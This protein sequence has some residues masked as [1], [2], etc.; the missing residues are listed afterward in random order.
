MKSL[1]LI[2]YPGNEISQNLNLGF[3]L[4]QLLLGQDTEF[5]TENF[6][7]VII[8][9]EKKEEN[10]SAKDNEMLQVVIGQ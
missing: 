3:T 5:W 9:K 8:A 6:I 1:R 7:I 10:C 2:L 4:G